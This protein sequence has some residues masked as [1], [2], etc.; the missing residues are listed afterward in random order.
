L[1][2]SATPTAWKTRPTSPVT[3]VRNTKCL[4]SCSVSISCRRSSCRI[5]A[6][7][8]R[9]MPVAGRIYPLPSGIQPKRSRRPYSRR[10]ASLG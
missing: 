10:P 1:G 8:Q 5:S 3:G 2:G 4:S 6:P 9:S 7:H